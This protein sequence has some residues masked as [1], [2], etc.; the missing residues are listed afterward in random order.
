MPGS[1]AIGPAEARPPGRNTEHSARNVA[2]SVVVV[3]PVGGWPP[4]EKPV[5]VNLEAQALE[6]LRARN[7]RGN[8]NNQERRDEVVKPSSS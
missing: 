7:C 1:G 8:R 6:V 4:E 5:D 3:W 2:V